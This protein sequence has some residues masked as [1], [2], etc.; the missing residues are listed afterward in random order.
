M[1]TLS[2]TN[3]EQREHICWGNIMVRR[4]LFSKTTPRLWLSVVLLMTFKNLIRLLIGTK[5]SRNKQEIRIT[6]IWAHRTLKRKTQTLLTAISRHITWIKTHLIT[7]LIAMAVF[8]VKIPHWRKL[9][10]M[11]CCHLN[12]PTDGLNKTLLWR[13]FNK[14]NILIISRDQV[15]L[16]ATSNNSQFSKLLM[17][18]VLENLSG[19]KSILS[20]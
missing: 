4:Y 20:H 8:Q 12:Y 11:P 3:Q 9:C 5:R 6:I 16:K 18:L 19:T 17:V 7:L 14:L 10:E 15:L 2:K 1:K 13:R